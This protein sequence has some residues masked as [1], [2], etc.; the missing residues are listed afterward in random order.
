MPTKVCLVRAMVFP[1]VI[2][3]CESWTIKKAEHKRTDAFEL[4]CW[5]RLLRVPLDCKEIQPVYPKGNQWILNIHWKDWCWSWN[6]NT[7][8]TWCEGLTHLKRPRCWERL[9]AGGEADNRGWHLCHGW[10]ASP[11]WWTWVWVS[12]G[13]WWWTEKPGVW[14]FTE[15][16]RVGHYCGRTDPSRCLGLNL[17]LC[18]LSY[19]VSKQ[20][21]SFIA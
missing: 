21:A 16:Q 18:F 13:S 12:F 8:D 5:R 17:H 4:W 19:C 2:Y 3:E 11:T 14:Q 6:S 20:S 15:S 7:L 1:V 10:M 9:K